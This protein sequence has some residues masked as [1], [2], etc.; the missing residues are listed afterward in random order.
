MPRLTFETQEI[1]VSPEASAGESRGEVPVTVIKPNGFID[2]SS[3]PLFEKALDAV[4][5]ATSPS[6][7]EDAGRFSILDLSETH[8][9]NS[10]GISAIIRHFGVYRERNGLLVLVSVPKAVGLSMHLLGVTSFIP[11]HKDMEHATALIR[12]SLVG[13][14]AASDGDAVARKSARDGKRVFVPLRRAPSPLKDAHI[15]LVTP[16]D[17]RFVRI[18]RQRYHYLNGQFHIRHD[19]DDALASIDDTKPDVIL[20]D[21]RMDPLGDF[22]MRLKMNPNLSLISVIKIYD[23]EKG[24]GELD[25]DLDFKIWENDYLVDPFEILALFSLAEA[26]LLRVPK[27]RKVFQQQVRFQFRVSEENVERA[28]RL[29]EVL[30]SGVL[31]T[32]EDRTAMCAAI[33]EGIDNAVVHGSGKNESKTIDINFLID[34]SKLTVIVQDEGG[35]FDYEYYLA[36]VEDRDHLERARRNIIEEGRRGGLGIILMHRCTD[37]IEYSGVGNLLRLEK[38]LR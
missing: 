24:S 37:R 10:T 11:F 34:R 2:S 4:A 12:E 7:G 28:I 27:D 38:N 23:S 17:N 18:L 29:S 26:A 1:Q 14:V 8:Y 5:A 6:G 35:G 31:S 9:I 33:K 25:T 20:I 19:T 13:G 36:H 32:E 3:C 30:V 22:V 21:S 15:L 16:S